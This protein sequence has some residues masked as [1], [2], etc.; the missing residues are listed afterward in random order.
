M[1]IDNS[2]FFIFLNNYNDYC[3][4]VSSKNTIDMDLELLKNVN[5]FNFYHFIQFFPK[6]KYNN[7][8]YKVDDF[9]CLD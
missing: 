6:L 3:L 4:N 5:R 9:F 8:Q 2:L 1:I 7:K